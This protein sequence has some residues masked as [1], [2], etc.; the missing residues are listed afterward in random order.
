MVP[1]NY[2]GTVPTGVT[3]LNNNLGYNGEGQNT[4][5]P[6]A[7]FA[8][9]LPGTDRFVLRGGYGIY[10]DRTT[11]QPFIQLLTD[12]PFSK[13]NQ[14]TATQNAN[15]TIA[16]PF[17]AATSVPIFPAYSPTTSAGLTILDPDYRAP[18]SHHYSMGLQTKLTKDMVLTATYDGMRG[19]HLLEVRNINQADLASASNPIRGLTTNT[20]ANTPQRVPIEG[21]TATGITDI[22]SNGESWYNALDVTRT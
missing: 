2:S 21:F 12:P 15:A 10:H 11:G 19:L 4:W 9:Q 7:G 22:Q 14:L 8:W 3:K 5:N 13:L 18:T 1:S 17:P 20:V 6:R 16:N